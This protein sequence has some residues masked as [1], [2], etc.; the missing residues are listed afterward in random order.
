[1]K[2]TKLM[3]AIA[4]VTMAVTSMAVA[5]PLSASATTYT[6]YMLGDVDGDFKISMYDAYTVLTALDN[7]GL[8][9]GSR[10]SVSYVQSHLSDW[11]PNAVCA[12]AADAD[13][14][15][16]ISYDDAQDILQCYSNNAA[17]LDGYKN[18]GNL[19]VYVSD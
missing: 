5:M 15:G 3:A 13:Q 2:K 17:G 6:A 7:H 8:A 4:A 19:Y 12:K 1:M 18:I 16:Y 11:F 10:V 14:D 9:Q